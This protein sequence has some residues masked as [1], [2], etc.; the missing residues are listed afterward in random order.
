MSGKAARSFEDLK[1]Y[2]LAR[3]LTN[4][5]YRLT[6]KESFRATSDWWIRFDGLVYRSCRISRKDSNGEPQSS[7]FSFS[8]LPKGHAAKSAPSSR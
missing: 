2:Q 7:L 1:M 6:R 4:A 5:V 3:D 8:I